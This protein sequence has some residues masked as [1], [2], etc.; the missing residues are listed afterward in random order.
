[1]SGQKMK[2]GT[3]LHIDNC[4]EEEISAWEILES[5]YFDYYPDKHDDAEI[6]EWDAWDL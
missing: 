4:I 2:T 1:M 3:G 5:V 6:E